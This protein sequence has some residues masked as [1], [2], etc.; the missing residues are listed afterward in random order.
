MRIQFKTILTV[1][2]LILASLLVNSFVSY[3]FARNGITGL[4]IEYLDYK[5]DELEKYA[6]SQWDLLAE[7]RLSENPRYI[8]IAEQAI[9]IFA[10]SLI[11]KDSELIFAVRTDNTIAI[12]T[13]KT[14]ASPEEM[15]VLAEIMKN[16]KGGWQKLKLNGETRVCQISWFEP[17][18]WFLFVSEKEKNFYQSSNTILTQSILTLGITIA[19][20][21]LLL[22]F[23]TRLITRPVGLLSATIEEIIMTGNLEKKA[24]VLYGDEIGRLGHTFNIMTA[25]LNMAYAQVREFAH[26]AVIAK[27]RETYIRN[28][29]Q[30][31]VPKNI[32][33]QF[34]ANP[35]ASLIGKEENLAVLLSD[36]RGF[37]MMLEKNNSYQVVSCLSEYFEI[38]VKIIMSQNGIADK[39]LGDR[40]LAFFGAPVRGKNDAVNAVLS[41]LAMIKALEQFNLNQKLKNMPAFDIG[42][43]IDYGKTI[44][45]NVGGDMKMEYTIFG[46]TVKLASRLEALTKTYHEPV[47]ISEDV[48]RHLD[49]EI[50]CR[51][52]D[53]IHFS[54]L[55]RTMK[56][57][58]PDNN[59]SEK[60][61]LAWKY[62]KE[63]LILYYKRDFGA[64][65]KEFLKVRE[66]LIED[67]CSEI[68]LQ[69]CIKYL[70]EPPDSFWNGTE[71]AEQANHIGRQEKQK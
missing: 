35:D 55:N 4:A 29:F 45:G 33:D 59:L 49:S 60:K 15:A 71:I 70:A 54:Q 22:F 10:R 44:A 34:A 23:F 1:L 38:M 27:S 43:G 26:K 3:L 69:R 7:N 50:P 18:K 11:R 5:R 14:E 17:L 56:I 21:V 39:Y 40:I 8:S 28:I 65:K 25:Q 63:G 64:A 68:F 2:P 52:L 36:V 32:I 20:A 48:F 41:A 6:K 53:S 42:I 61:K 62:H 66:I 46:N 9:G 13:G 16:T 57:Y 47:I 30:K 19:L 31:Y 58:T 51:M 67:V 24:P 37:S 12:S